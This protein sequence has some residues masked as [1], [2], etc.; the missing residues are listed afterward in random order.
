MGPCCKVCGQWRYGWLTLN[1]ER[2][3]ARCCYWAVRLAVQH[4]NL[5]LVG[6][7]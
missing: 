5:N 3:C 1:R 7:H 4:L 2:V 6:W